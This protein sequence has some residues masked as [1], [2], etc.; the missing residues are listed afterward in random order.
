MTHPYITPLGSATSAT[1]GAKAGGLA[2]LIKLGMPVPSGFAISCQAF[3]RFKG[4]KTTD[5]LPKSFVREFRER[6][7]GLGCS[8]KAVRSSSSI[9]DGDEMSHAGSFLSR[10]N[11]AS[12]SDGLDAVLAVW[13]SQSRPAVE[14]SGVGTMGVIVQCMVDAESS[15]VAFSVD[16]TTGDQ[17][18]YVEWV[19]G[20]GEQ[21][22]SGARLDGR[23]WLSA[24]A[25]HHLL[26]EDVLAARRLPRPQLV[27]V[28]TLL[29]KITTQ[30]KRA[31][32]IEWAYTREH[33]VQLVQSRPVTRVVER[34]AG[35]PPIWLVPTP[36]RQGWHESTK[37]LFSLWNE[38]NPPAIYPLE[39]ELVFRHV[40]QAVLDSQTKNIL[41]VDIDD[42]VIRFLGVPVYIDPSK[43]AGRML[44]RPARLDLHGWAILQESW[45]AD[46]KR[47]EAYEPEC[48]SNRE[49]AAAVLEVSVHMRRAISTRIEN[50][51]WIEAETQLLD[52]IR[53]QLGRELL[54]EE[55]EALQISIGSDTELFQ[56]GLTNLRRLR[57]RDGPASEL[58][59]T[60][61]ELVERFGHFSFDG[62][63]LADSPDLVLGDSA[64]RAEELFGPNFPAEDVLSPTIKELSSVRKL[65]EWYRVRED[66]KTRQ[67]YL[68]PLFNRL[69]T[70]A[71]CRL[72]HLSTY[73]KVGAML[74]TVQEL[75]DSLSEG[76]VP[77]SVLTELEMR[78]EVVR[79][80]ARQSWLPPGFE[81]SAGGDCSHHIFGSPGSP[82]Q[83]VG[84]ARI[85]FGVR[86]FNQVLPG[87]IVVAR[88]T[89]PVWTS[90]FDRAAGLVIE[91]GSRLSHASIVARERG[92]PAVV[93]V[94][95]ATRLFE[96]GEP[97]EVDGDSGR[98]V[99]LR[100]PSWT[101]PA[102]QGRPS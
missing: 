78:S 8:R 100:H 43:E 5:D 10:L 42:A 26:R 19:R 99:R 93:G 57:G 95:D 61:E 81:D 101:G 27:E 64:A 51:T 49:L 35:T 20:L 96:D 79:W 29:R 73:G 9:E 67:D 58:R 50:M 7:D 89:N 16:P 97:L 13:D 80:K 59:R 92:I 41:G 72:R 54:P 44:P 88:S 23:A 30:A 71:S 69:V 62:T 85:V 66:T 39:Y 52:E 40:W 36:P 2:Q 28:S 86:E 90:L 34:E 102:Q 6:W 74:L 17:C 38:Y 32:D 70:E 47:L 84:S 22:V 11:V 87:D 82:G 14:L 75:Q 48:L 33:G 1:Y 77:T 21:L 37:R 68:R 76:G 91:N 98:I 65:R 31:C 3:D 53:A 56:R 83:C 94:R 63:C 4:A 46:R 45:K 55:L 24:A 12:A 18:C 15:G 60:A 25:P